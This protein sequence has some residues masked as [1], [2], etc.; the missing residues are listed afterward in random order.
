MHISKQKQGSNKRNLAKEI[1]Y[2]KKL[3]DKYDIDYQS[4]STH[5]IIKKKKGVE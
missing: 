2:N 4:S 1:Y 3:N 5:I